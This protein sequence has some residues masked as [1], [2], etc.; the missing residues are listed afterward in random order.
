MQETLHDIA[1]R[2][3]TDKALHGF[4]HI[5]DQAF[6]HL[7]NESIRFMEVGIWMGCSI[8]MWE[9]YFTNATIIAA[10]R[11]TEEERISESKT[12]DGGIYEG[13]ELLP[14]TQTFVADQEKEWELLALPGD[15]D[16]IIEDGGHTM[17]QQQ[18]SLKTLFLNKLKP[19]GYYVL[20]DLHTSQDI[21][22]PWGHSWD[23]Y[24]A[25]EYNRTIELLHDLQRGKQSE[26]N[27]YYITN[28]DFYQLLQQIES[29]EI[30]NVKWGS[31]TAI[32]KKKY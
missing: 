6:S 24:G 21:Q 8:K 17:L 28:H 22:Y 15:L 32:I 18:L 13:I 19:G 11:M 3:R 10:D 2:C 25:N 26:N 30:F 5:Y 12:F 14:T 31:T 23:L 27:Q 1:V 4:T 16:I 9:E 7:R 29:I 20:E